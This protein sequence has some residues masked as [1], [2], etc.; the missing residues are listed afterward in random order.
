MKIISDSTV[1]CVVNGFQRT[2][3]E[4]VDGNQYL[5]FPDGCVYGKYGEIKGSIEP[6]HIVEFEL[7]TVRIEKETKLCLV[8][9]LL[10]DSLGPDKL[11]L[12]FV[13]E[14][15]KS[16]IQDWINHVNSMYYHAS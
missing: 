14:E 5:V 8:L 10:W 2:G 9:N 12:G 15:K 13:P 1:D 4:N 3:F 6:A 11:M 16:I 7:R